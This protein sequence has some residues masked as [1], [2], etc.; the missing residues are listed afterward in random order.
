MTAT[1]R[2]ATRISKETKAELYAC[3]TQPGA[4]PDFL[5]EEALRYHLRGLREIPEAMMI[6]G[7]LVPTTESLDA[8]ADN[9]ARNEPPTDALHGLFRE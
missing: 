8:I 6:P 5:I 7:R 2:I 1:T 4:R 3:V 9:I